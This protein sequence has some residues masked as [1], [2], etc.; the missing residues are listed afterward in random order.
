M[1]SP[2]FLKQVFET[3]TLVIRDPSSAVKFNVT[4]SCTDFGSVIS[5][6]KVVKSNLNKARRKMYSYVNDKSKV[7]GIRETIDKY[8][9][10]KEID[11]IKESFQLK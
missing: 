8:V 4:A 2:F 5:Y 1:K 9:H 6:F 3:N 11:L 10:I 7:E